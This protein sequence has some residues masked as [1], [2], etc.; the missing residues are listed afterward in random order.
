MTHNQ[1]NGRISVKKIKKVKQIVYSSDTNPNISRSSIIR[2]SKLQKSRST[3]S[4]RSWLPKNTSINEKIKK[5]PNDAGINKHSSN[6]TSNA[7]TIYKESE[8]KANDP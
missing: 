5:N 3:V 7:I 2:A 4:R 6:E 1:Q 8:L